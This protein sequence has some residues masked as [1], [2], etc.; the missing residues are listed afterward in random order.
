MNS[1]QIAQLRTHLQTQFYTNAGAL[2]HWIQA[3]FGVHYHSQGLVKLLH[4]I[5]FA[6]RK[7][8]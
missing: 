6:Y 1:Q 8:D 5:G 7:T 3:S 2:Y 4:R